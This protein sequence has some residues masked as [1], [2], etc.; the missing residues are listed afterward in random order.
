VLLATL[1]FILATNCAAWYIVASM[2][3][4]EIINEIAGSAQNTYLGYFNE[5]EAWLGYEFWSSQVEIDIEQELFNS[6]A[7]ESNRHKVV[8]ETWSPYQI[9]QFADV[10]KDRGNDAL[11]F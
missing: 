1:Y 5:F 2:K 8:V 3:Q 9:A 4:T 6:G 7:E 11:P 10:Q